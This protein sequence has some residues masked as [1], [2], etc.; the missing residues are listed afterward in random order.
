MKAKKKQIR[1]I[2]ISRIM[3]LLRWHEEND[4]NKLK[5]TLELRSDCSGSISNGLK[6]VIC[7]WD[8]LEELNERIK[9]VTD[10]LGTVYKKK[11]NDKDYNG[12]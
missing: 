2:T 12:R 9:E 1:A 4:E 3:T 5:L 11:W 8:G 10:K 7:S 6:I